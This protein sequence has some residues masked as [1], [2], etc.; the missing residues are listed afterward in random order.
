[1]TTAAEERPGR[2]GWMILGPASE[3]GEER[4][5]SDMD[6]DRRWTLVMV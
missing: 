5:A 4:N 1:M 6:M 2:F 3:I